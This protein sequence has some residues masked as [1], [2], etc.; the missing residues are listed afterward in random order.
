[1]GLEAIAGMLHVP[2]S[3]GGKDFICFMR[4]EEL[5]SVRWAGRPT[6]N[7]HTGEISLQPRKSFDIWSEMVQGKCRAWTVEQQEAA[8]VLRL[9]YATVGVFCFVFFSVDECF[10]LEVY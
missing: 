9:V 6:K 7:A 4:R 3:R 2:L 1:L 5:M 10:V 8:A